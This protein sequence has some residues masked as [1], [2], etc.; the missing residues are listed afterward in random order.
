MTRYR[1]FT[2]EVCLHGHACDGQT[3]ECE[4]SDWSCPLASRIPALHAR[5]G[6]LNRQLQS[7]EAHRTDSDD[8]SHASVKL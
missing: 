1:P 6:T 2:Y 8:Q 3:F 5:G 7:I 4:G